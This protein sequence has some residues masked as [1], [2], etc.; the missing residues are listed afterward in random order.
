M[1]DRV[2]HDAAMAMVQA[3]IDQ[4]GLPMEGRP[5]L[6]EFYRICRAGIEAYEINLDRMQRRLKPLDN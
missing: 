1:N 3:L 2:V 4:V 5:T 6:A